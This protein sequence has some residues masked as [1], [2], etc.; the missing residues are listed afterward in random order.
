MFHRKKAL[1]RAAAPAVILSLALT[2]CGSDDS[3]DE[4]K[5][6]KA[7][8]SQ[9]AGSDDAEEAGD[10]DDSDDAAAGDNSGLAVG[11]KAN[12]QHK[13]ERG[14][15]SAQLEVTAE[16]VD[17]GTNADLVAAGLEGDS[18]KGM[19]PVFVYFNYTVKEAEALEPDTDFNN[20]VGV[21]GPGDKPGKKLIAIGGDDIKG[22]CPADA[23]DPAWKVG[24]SAT[25]CTTFVMPEG[26]DVAK[27]AYIGDMRNPVMWD[28]KDA[29]K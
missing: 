8:T 21:L 11:D 18:T 17:V 27:V 10:T 29:V 2:A 13:W 12:G 7:E 23:K 6:D 19:Y 20:K 24:T 25:L 26:T 3:D 9:D 4:G 1:L 14:N 15:S 28:A 5:S 22:G 16:K